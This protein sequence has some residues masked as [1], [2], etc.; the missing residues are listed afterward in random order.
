MII[1]SLGSNLGDKHANIMAA[2]EHIACLG[3]VLGV[4]EYYESDPWGFE[5]DNAFLNV[6]LILDCTM[7]V[8]D[9]LDALKG[10]ERE[11]GRGEKSV[12]CVYTDRVIDIDIIDY[13]GMVIEADSLVCP[14]VLMHKR[15]F[16]LVPLCELLPQWVHPVLK[17]TA[18]ELR[19][20]CDQLKI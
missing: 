2:I 20:C 3:S 5:S 10:I 1:L 16:V 11:M 12:G 6:V 17:K 9:L 19:D 15:A 14:H 13:K 4:S 8:F 18:V 7:D